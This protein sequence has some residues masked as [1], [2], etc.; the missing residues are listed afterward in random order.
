ME[1]IS[2]IE[3]LISKFLAGDASPEEAMLLEDWKNANAT[4]NAYYLEC[5]K[6]FNL[7]DNQSDIESDT[8]LAWNKINSNQT[9]QEVK[10][11]PIT[12]NRLPLFAAAAS[13]IVLICVGLY[14]S[15]IRNS[16]VSTS[17]FTALNSEKKVVLNDSTKTII[18]PNSSL[19][20]ESGFNV[21]HR[22]VKL[23]GS[24]YFDIKHDEKLP[25]AIQMGKFNIKDIGTKFNVRTSKNNDSI[26]VSVDEGIVEISNQKKERITLN[27]NKSGYY[28]V[29]KD[30]VANLDLLDKKS[31][32]NFNF[33]NA[34]LQEVVTQL[35]EAYN[36]SIKLDNKG[37]YDCTYTSQFKNEK[38]DVV[39]MVITE[40]LGLELVELSKNE[41]LI[42][43]SKCVR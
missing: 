23:K 35:S 16:S 26:F 9:E 10:I 5:E 30:E 33:K 38:I 22:N 3:D 1:N 41:Y 24:A 31:V 34:R 29:S 12:K 11:V 2:N 6:V 13:V 39:L 36:V 42:K 19:E 14:V 18:A 40:T 17:T 7:V 21:K 4:N 32:L 27:A 25:F 43:G 28:V 37:Q 8:E 15:F 20:I